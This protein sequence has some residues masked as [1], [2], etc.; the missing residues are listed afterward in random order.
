MKRTIFLIT[1]LV[2]AALH[3]DET[4]TKTFDFNGRG[5]RALTIDNVWGSIHVAGTSGSQARV[6]IHKSIKG[7]VAAAEREVKLDV[8]QE[9][10]DVTFYVDMPSRHHERDH[11]R[12]HEYTVIMN[13]DVEVPRD[14]ALTL[15]TVTDGNID[16]RGVSGD[17]A[18]HNV[19]GSIDM[20]DVAGSGDAK[21]VNGHVK[22]A[23]RGNPTRNSEFSTINGAIELDFSRGLSADFRFSTMNG[24]IYSDYELASL[25]TRETQGERTNGKWVYRSDRF[26]GGRVGAGGPEITIRNLNGDIRVLE[27]P[28]A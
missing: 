26:K 24:G 22:V 27:R 6:V 4:I 19:N 21:T 7:D 11:R 3:G 14:I 8:S 20:E 17:F 2:A 1:F 12:D 28:G 10:N 9:Q 18:V 25:P 5:P 16:V 15:K 23:F 13:F